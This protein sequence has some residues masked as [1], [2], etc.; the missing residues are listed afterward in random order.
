MIKSDA[1][2]QLSAESHDAHAHDDPMSPED[3]REMTIMC[4]LKVFPTAEE[5][6]PAARKSFAAMALASTPSTASCTHLQPNVDCLG[7][8]ILLLLAM[9]SENLH[10][11]KTPMEEPLVPRQASSSLRAS[12][13]PAQVFAS[14]LAKPL[15]LPHSPCAVPYISPLPQTS[16]VSKF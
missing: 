14:L 16:T 10:Q 3:V 6:R 9:F 8:K 2:H 15:S 7:T 12:G 1:V 4:L 5:T 13:A 11:T